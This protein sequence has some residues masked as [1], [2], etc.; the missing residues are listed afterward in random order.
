MKQ[1]INKHLLSYSDA[2]VYEI[3]YYDSYF[4]VYYSWRLFPDILLIDR[5]PSKHLALLHKY[6][7][8]HQKPDS[9]FLALYHD[10]REQMERVY[11]ERYKLGRRLDWK[12]VQYLPPASAEL[13]TSMN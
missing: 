10:C 12:L 6:Q 4:E 5:V 2:V 7:H 11:F 9:A 13:K 3:K 1:R 8:R